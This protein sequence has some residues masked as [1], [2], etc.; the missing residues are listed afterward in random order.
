MS[1]CPVIRRALPG[2][3][4]GV[5]ATVAAA[6]AQDPGWAF[7]LG[8]EYERLVTHFAAAVFDARVE[9]HNVWVTDDL[10]VLPRVVPNAVDG[11][12]VA[13]AAV[14]PCGVVVVQPDG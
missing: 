1:T 2:E 3:R 11:W 6:F 13:D 5:V 12:P 14:V 8:G 7:I 4:T 10:A 9:S